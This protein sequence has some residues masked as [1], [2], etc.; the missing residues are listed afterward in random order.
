MT[1]E[2]KLALALAEIQREI[3]SIQSQVT[4]LAREVQQ[5]TDIWRGCACFG[6][7]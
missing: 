4:Q 6:G 5:M 7:T 2:E 3:A 1:P